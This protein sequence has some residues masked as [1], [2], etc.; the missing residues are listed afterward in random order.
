MLLKQS[1][2]QHAE[3]IVDKQRVFFINV[4]D[5]MGMMINLRTQPMQ[6]SLSNTFKSQMNKYETCDLAELF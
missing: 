5:T 2:K 3:Q 1:W 6:R 4:N